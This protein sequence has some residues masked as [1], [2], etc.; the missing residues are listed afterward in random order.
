MSERKIIVIG[1]SNLDLV[2]RA[3]HIPAPGETIMGDSLRMIPGGKGANQAVAVARLGDG[4]T[5]V[6]KLGADLFG[7]QMR[8][9]LSQENLDTSYLLTDPDLPNGVALITVDDQ[10]E[11]SIVVAP[12][13][14]GNLLPADLANVLPILDQAEIVLM[15]LETPIE[16]VEFI[17]EYLAD[18]K[19]LFVLNPAPA[20]KLSDTLLSHVDLLTPNETEASIL[21]GVQVVDLDSARCAAA[22]LKEK[23]VDRII[24]T[25]GEKGALISENDDFILV[26]AEKVTPVDTTAAG[27]VFNGALCVALS[28]GKDLVSAVRFASSAA[29]IS[30]TRMGA[31]SSIPMRSEI[32]R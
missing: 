10:G 20:G 23:G 11:N 32:T 15:Q 6:S 4:G 5:F 18:K 21:S 14:N 29:A 7:D 24:V 13:A 31:Q 9:V 19:A 30:V 27:D 1:S 16:T 25:L 17:A 2:V 3:G 8:E 28:E 26:E 22:K 12:G